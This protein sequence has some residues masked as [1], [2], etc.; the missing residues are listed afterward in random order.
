MEAKDNENNVEEIKDQV[1]INENENQN[2]ELAAKWH[3]VQP[4]KEE[5][6]EKKE[7]KLFY[8]ILYLDN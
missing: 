5:K 4:Q 3:T 2:E 6:Q 8:P 7:K 1:N